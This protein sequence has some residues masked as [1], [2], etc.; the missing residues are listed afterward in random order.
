MKNLHQ[1]F[2][3]NM[4]DRLL[5]ER[6]SKR[7]GA[8]T[9][10]NPLQVNVENTQGRGSAGFRHADLVGASMATEV[11]N[12]QRKSG[13]VFPNIDAGITE[14]TSGAP[15]AP[16]QKQLDLGVHG[17]RKA[18]T[19]TADTVAPRSEADTVRYSFSTKNAST[20]NNTHGI[21]DDGHVITH[22]WNPESSSWHDMKHELEYGQGYKSWIRRNR[23]TEG[24]A[25]EETA[26]MLLKGEALNKLATLPRRTT[27]GQVKKM[28]GE[29]LTG[30][31]ANPD[32][33]FVNYDREAKN[34][35]VVRIGDLHDDTP[36][37]LSFAKRNP[38]SDRK[39]SSD[40]SIRFNMR[41]LM[42][43][44]RVNQ[45][46]G[47]GLS[48]AGLLDYFTQRHRDSLQASKKEVKEWVCS[49]LRSKNY[50]TGEDQS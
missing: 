11:L 26:E 23:T 9:M 49:F 7:S 39:A 2:L 18:Y 27:W 14:I 48:S 12:R 21:R 28:W 6:R 5:L 35:S 40:N 17:A 36:L 38:E 13:Q 50:L 1:T 29:E 8:P 34:F 20:N 37:T 43:H 32:T 24:K 10:I 16:H 45:R 42:E 44:Q 15:T 46:G 41:R 19:L 22:V 4:K 31:L 3:T 47:H 33:H 30:K 25:R